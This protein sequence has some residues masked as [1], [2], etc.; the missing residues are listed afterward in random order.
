MMLGMIAY[1]KLTAHVCD[2]IIGLSTNVK[3]AHIKISMLIASKSE[4]PK[5][6]TNYKDQEACVKYVNVKMVDVTS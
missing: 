2:R 1:S 4:R 5:A 3:D 6:V